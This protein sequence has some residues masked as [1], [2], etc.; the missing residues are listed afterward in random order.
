MTANTKRILLVEDNI[1]GREMVSALLEDE[2]FLCR[3]ACNGIEALDLVE[4][5]AFDLILLD[6][7]MPLLNGYLTARNMRSLGVTAPIVALTAH[8]LD[9]Q[10][11]KCIQY[12]MNGCISKP[13]E[14]ESMLG[15][16]REHLSGTADTAGPAPR[17]N[18]EAKL[19]RETAIDLAFLEELSKGRTDFFMSM[20]DIFITQNQ[21]D[22]KTLEAAIS[23]S[24][25]CTIMLMA[26]KIRTSVSF[27]GLDKRLNAQLEEIEL[28]AEDKMNLARITQL[29]RQ[30]SAICAQAERELSQVK[31]KGVIA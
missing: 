8:D 5:S 23:T 19:M 1:L 3:V 4:D 20:I 26:H 10:R 22:M 14:K 28:L 2:G 21:G 13:F 30:V 16:I 15:V 12:G 24:D 9:H 29:F 7:E 27:V 31:Q 6:I 18:P 25:F 17:R 11:K